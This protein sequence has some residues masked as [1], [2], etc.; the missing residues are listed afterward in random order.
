MTKYVWIICLFVLTG[1]AYAAPPQ[2]FTQA[3][4]LAR[5]SVYADR[6]ASGDLYCG[7]N[8]QWAGKSGGIV[9]MPSCGYKVRA[10]IN[11]ASR[12]EWEHIVP[13]STFGRQRQCWQNGGRSNCNATDPVFNVMEADLHNLSPVVGEVNGDRSNFNVGM[14]S[15]PAGQYGQCPFKVDFQNRVAEPPNSAKGQV[16]RVH[17]YMADRYG[18]NFSQQQERVLMSWDRAFPPTAWEVERDRRIARVMGHGNAFVSRQKVWTPGYRPSREGI[19]SQV[20]QR[21]AQQPRPVAPTPASVPVSQSQQTAEPPVIGNRNSKIYHVRGICPGYEATSP[22][23]R[24][25]FQSEARA[26]AAGFRR[27]GN[28]R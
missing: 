23:N 26:A 16:A 1:A 21:P 12:I 2:N 11:R 19:Q 24:I 8:W 15:S 5:T 18:L 22:Q 4:E 3:K 14:A 17:F 7:C 10:Q 27:A 9:D 6:N 25:P 13:A 20:P 28:C